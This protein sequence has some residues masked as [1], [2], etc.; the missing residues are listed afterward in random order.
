MKMFFA[1]CIAFL[2]VACSEDRGSLIAN[3]R[4]IGGG[5]SKLELYLVTG[6]KVASESSARYSFMI[7]GDRCEPRKA[8]GKR[9]AF[10]EK[11]RAID[12]FE[13]SDDGKRVRLFRDGREFCSAASGSALRAFVS[14]FSGSTVSVSSNEA[15][16]SNSVDLA[17]CR[18]KSM[19][20]AVME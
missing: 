3:V 20:G 16:V 4:C 17:K 15:L 12:Y 2:M 1:I 9:L 14:V 10:L 18:I 13:I 8:K 6:G 7:S 5:K 11:Y 19:K